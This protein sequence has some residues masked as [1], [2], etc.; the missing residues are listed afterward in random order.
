[1]CFANLGTLT[2]QACG[3]RVGEQLVGM[4]PCWAMCGKFVSKV[5]GE[6]VQSECRVCRDARAERAD[7]ARRL[8][9]AS[10]SSREGGRGPGR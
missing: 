10:G 5:T 8:T 3:R 2:C 6:V 1:M 4:T 7:L 9:R